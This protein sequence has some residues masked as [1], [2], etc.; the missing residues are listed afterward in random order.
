MKSA[1]ILML[2]FV[3]LVTAQQI[4]EQLTQQILQQPA[5]QESSD[6]VPDVVLSASLPFYVPAGYS[7]NVSLKAFNSGRSVVENVVVDMAQTNSSVFIEGSTQRALGSLKPGEEKEIRYTLYSSY[8]TPP[9]TYYVPVKVSYLRH[10]RAFSYSTGIGV[11]VFSPQPVFSINI[12]DKPLEVGIGGNVTV[13]ITNAGRYPAY[14]AYATIR[15]AQQAPQEN[16]TASGAASLLGGTPTSGTSGSADNTMVAGSTT[17][18]LGDIEPGE[19]KNVSYYIVP[20][21]DLEPGTYSYE[22][23]ISFY[24]QSANQ[25]ISFSYP[26][27]ILFVGRPSI[28]LSSIEISQSIDGITISGDANNVGSETV[29]S[30]ILEATEDDYFAPAYSGSTYYVGTMEPDDFIPFELKVMNKKPNIGPSEYNISIRYLDSRNEERVELFTL[31]MPP[32]PPEAESSRGPSVLLWVALLF[33]IIVIAVAVII[34]L[35]RRKR[36]G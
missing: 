14:S 3:S 2:L 20:N 30:I 28:Y 10:N 23:Q 15:R 5:Q 32:K 35:R 26:F 1:I 22:M 12:L 24:P 7:V 21:A 13:K 6:F 8:E 19:Q 18:F 36:N 33:A 34:I 17:I 25:S 31:T 4:P 9:G 11:S 27:G 29:K 16:A